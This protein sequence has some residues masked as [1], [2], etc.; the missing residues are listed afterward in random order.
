MWNTN[1]FH[2]FIEKLQEATALDE[3][4]TESLL[5]LGAIMQTKSDIEAAL[6]QYRRIPDIQDEGSEVW[7]NIGLCFKG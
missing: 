1:L 5:A 6:N 2:F 3:K 4:H 7:S